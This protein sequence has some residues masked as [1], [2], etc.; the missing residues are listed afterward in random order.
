M[1]LKKSVFKKSVP[2][3][4]IQN[5]IFQKK[6]FIG[7][8]L[9]ASLS[10]LLGLMLLTGCGDDSGESKEREP[11]LPLY[12]VSI[13]GT[14][15]RMGETTVQT[16]LDQ[17]LSV[18]VSEM[19][20]NNQITQYEIDPEA[21]LEPNSYY[22]GASVHISDSIFAHIAMATD[23]EAVR[24]GNSTI[25]WMEF[26]LGGETEERARIALNG[27]PVS[28]IDQEKAIEMFPEFSSYDYYMSSKYDP[29]YEYTL[30]FS[31]QDGLLSK[32]TVKRKYD[33][34][35]SDTDGR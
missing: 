6:T 25:A 18:T 30:N 17:G 14:E 3:N 28:E 4:S 16:L 8:R 32:F 21:I 19:D 35:W 26:Y 1:K 20:S 24:M 9:S 10:L 5:R 12:P 2:R 27:V 11:A 33:V 29:I 34:D 13:N 15:I 31:Q 23:D 7:K 22:S